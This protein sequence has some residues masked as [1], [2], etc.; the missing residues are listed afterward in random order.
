VRKRVCALIASIVLGVTLAACSS[1]GGAAGSSGG[2]YVIGYVN[3]MSGAL[4]VYGEYSLTYVQA[5]VKQANETGGINGHQVEI[6]VLDS[7]APGQTPVSAMQQMV[8]QYHPIVVYGNTLTT[9]CA[10]TAP[11]A[12]K[13]ETPLVCATTTAAQIK[14]VQPYLFAS[15]ANE[16]ALSAPAVSFGLQGLR[17]AKGATYA[18]VISDSSGGTDFASG[19]DAQAKADG[20]NKV[21]AEAIPF[22]IIDPASQISHLAAAKPDV[23]FV[24]AVGTLVTAVAQGLQA[25]GVKTPVVDILPSL[26]YNGLVALDDP[27]FYEVAQ[28]NFVTDQ[29][30]ASY[31]GV[32]KIQQIL[33]AGGMVGPTV[34][35]QQLGAQAVLPALGMLDGIRACGSSCTPQ[36]MATALQTVSLNLPGF[37]SSYKWTSA[38]HVPVGSVTV[39]SYDPPTKTIKTDATGLAVGPVTSTAP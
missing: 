2:D 31:T 5:A 22:T 35:N 9:D 28:T 24:D 7:Y 32:A 13:Y 8:T 6:K 16:S 20:L 38:S 11:I 36:R 23:V 15:Q 10:A 26:G 17:L 21:D 14:S 19:V 27:D 25:A 34:Q 1:G 33:T 39:V 4:A 3:G 29:T 30:A 37:I 12:A 18:T